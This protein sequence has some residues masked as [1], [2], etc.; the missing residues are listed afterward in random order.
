M[1]EKLELGAAR[2]VQARTSALQQTFDSGPPIGKCQ[3]THTGSAHTTHYTLLLSP[4]V[5]LSSTHYTTPFSLPL[6]LDLVLVF[7]HISLIRTPKPLA[8]STC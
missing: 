5:C 3:H 6:P 8:M 2:L 7:L 1:R 4:F